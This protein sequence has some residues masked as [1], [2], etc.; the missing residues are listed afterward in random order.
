MQ[1]FEQGMLVKSKAGHDKDDLFVII[2]VE[3]EYVYLVDGK[4]RTF[5]SPKKKKLKHVQHINYIDEDLA[6]KLRESKKVIDEEI[7][8][9]IK[10]YKVKS[11]ML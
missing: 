10:L 8:R 3:D 1:G 2:K 4:F 5:Q 6:F 7:K 9:A 11:D